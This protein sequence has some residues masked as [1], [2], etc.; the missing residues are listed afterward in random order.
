MRQRTFALLVADHLRQT[1]TGDAWSLRIG[2][3]FS[4]ATTSDLEACLS[5]VAAAEAA[6]PASS[7]RVKEGISRQ[8]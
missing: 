1:D 7:N 8:I 6:S 2:P 4:C 5:G 3:L